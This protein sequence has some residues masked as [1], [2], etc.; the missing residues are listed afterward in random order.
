VNHEAPNAGKTRRQTCSYGHRQLDFI[1]PENLPVVTL[2]IPPD[3][4]QEEVLLVYQALMTA[5]IPLAHYTAK[6]RTVAVVISDYSRPTGTQI[7]TPILINRLLELGIER[8]HITIVIALGLHRPATSLEIIDLIGAEMFASM[9]VENHDA[10]HNLTYVDSIGFNATVLGADLIVLTGAVTF[11]P[12]AGYSGGYKS[13]L[14]GVAAKESILENHRLF[15][16]D[17]VKHPS[18]R[19]GSID[20]NPVLHHILEHCAR[21]TT[22]IFCLNVVLDQH[23]QIRFASAGS[24]LHAWSACCANVRDLNSVPTDRAY[25]WVLASAG[26]SPSDFSFYQC[27]KVLTHGAS[28]C[29][30]GGNLIILAECANGWEIDPDLL[31]WFSLPLDEVATLLL[32]DFRMDG[33]AVYMA[34]RIIHLHPVYF[35]SSLPPAQVLRTGMIPVADAASLQKLIDQQVQGTLAILPHGAQTLPLVENGAEPKDL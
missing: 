35:L 27:M 20:H 32:A 8:E 14:P 21:I 25:P 15:F 34:M 22:P 11:H 2:D 16:Q 10:L 1:L 23:K 12:M 7:Y 5:D 31:A 24:V 4:H 28:A 17:H 6:A 26:G 3:S 18:V 9:R 19:P 29:S 30:M 33:L 13:L